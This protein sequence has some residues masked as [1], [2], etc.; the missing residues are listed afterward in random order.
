MSLIVETVRQS[1]AR[2]VQAIGAFVIGACVAAC[3]DG[4]AFAQTAGNIPS[5]ISNPST[6]GWVRVRADGRTYRT[7]GC[8]CCGARA[9]GSPGLELDFQAFRGKAL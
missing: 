5:F 6:W 8:S 7:H 1:C 3:A 9:C 2:A 4:S